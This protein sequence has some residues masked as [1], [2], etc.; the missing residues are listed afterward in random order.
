MTLQKSK[1]EPLV[2][3]SVCLCEPVK[4]TR[5]SVHAKRMFVRIKQTNQKTLNTFL[6]CC[7]N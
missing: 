6:K 2:V 4:L 5:V 7:I 1:V 3:A